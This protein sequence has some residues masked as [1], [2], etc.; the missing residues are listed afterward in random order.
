MRKSRF[1]FTNRLM[2]NKPTTNH[3][4][5]TSISDLGNFF[6]SRC[7]GNRFRWPSRWTNVPFAEIGSERLRPAGAVY[8]DP[9]SSEEC[10]NILL[11]GMGIAAF[12]P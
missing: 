10:R 8:A 5:G 11:P 2:E 3:I 1:T 4:L 7:L 9:W 12:V 6:N